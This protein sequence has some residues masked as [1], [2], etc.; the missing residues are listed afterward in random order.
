ML[1]AE[2]IQ[3][4]TCAQTQMLAYACSKLWAAL[5]FWKAGEGLSATSCTRVCA[6]S[7]VHSIPAAPHGICPLGRDDWL[8]SCLHWAIVCVLRDVLIT[9]ARKSPPW[10]TWQVVPVHAAAAASCEAATAAAPWLLLLT[11]AATH[12]AAG[13][14]RYSPADW[15]RCATVLT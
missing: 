8:A 12:R 7:A 1:Q 10:G 14:R 11:A 15:P 5:T 3:A 4:H 9:P 13:S 6:A 2:S